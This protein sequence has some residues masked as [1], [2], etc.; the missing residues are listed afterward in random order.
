MNLHEAIYE[1]LQQVRHDRDIVKRRIRRSNSKEVIR[2]LRKLNNILEAT[3]L[4]L[5]GKL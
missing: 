3:E 4:K 1:R 2:G 5:E